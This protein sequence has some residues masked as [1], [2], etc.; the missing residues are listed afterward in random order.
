LKFNLGLLK[1]DLMKYLLVTIFAITFSVQLYSNPDST[2]FDAG[3]YAAEIDLKYQDAIGIKSSYM[4]K[5]L[6]ENTE[7]NYSMTIDAYFDGDFFILVD[8][9]END[10]G[11]IS[12]DEF[13]FSDG[14]LVMAVLNIKKKEEEDQKTK[15][16]YFLEQMMVMMKDEKDEEYG[17]DSPAFKKVQEQ[18]GWRITEIMDLLYK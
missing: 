10:N 16:C 17:T 9:Y 15:K 18:V 13:F 1:G 2:L 8:S 5:N 14:K 11:N 4:K 7:D 3:P 6:F 12:D